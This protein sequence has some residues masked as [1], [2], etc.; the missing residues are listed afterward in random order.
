MLT[1]ECSSQGDK[2]FSAFYAEV[3]ILNRF[4]N[5]ERHYQSSKKFDGKSSGSNK[6]RIPLY[7]KIGNLR[8]EPKYLTPWYKILWVRYLDEHPE[9]VSLIDLLISLEVR[10]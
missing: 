4:T 8:L 10:A 9:L 6:G 1:L 2:R 7:V 3:R 5:I